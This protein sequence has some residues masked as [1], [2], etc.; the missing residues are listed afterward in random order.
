MTDTELKEHLVGLHQSAALTMM[1]AASQRGPM[2]MPAVKAAD[3]IDLLMC[4]VEHYKDAGKLYASMKDS[5]MEEAMAEACA[6][7][8]DKLMELRKTDKE[9]NALLN[10][11]PMSGAK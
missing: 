3:R 8:M 2:G 11:H 6:S 1:V 9:V 4:A 5:Q 10:R 7:V